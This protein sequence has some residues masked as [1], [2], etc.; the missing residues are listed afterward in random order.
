MNRD[1]KC[2]YGKGVEENKGNIKVA[3][4]QLCFPKREWSLKKI[5]DWNKEAIMKHIWSLFAQ[6]GS[7]WA[8]WVYDNLL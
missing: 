8:A 2:S 3:W 4:D 1:S 5:E 6:A 7:L